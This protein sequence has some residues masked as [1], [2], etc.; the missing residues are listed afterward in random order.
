MLSVLFLQG[1]RF[2]NLFHRFPDIGYRGGT[3]PKANTRGIYHVI[4]FVIF[5]LYHS[6]MSNLPYRIRNLTWDCICFGAHI[7]LSNSVC[8]S[9]FWEMAID[10][11]LFTLLPF[12]ILCTCC[13]L[14]ILILDV[15]NIFSPLMC[16]DA[17]AVTFCDKHSSNDHFSC[18]YHAS[19]HFNRV[20]R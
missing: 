1:T 11:L 5:C 12:T 15:F 2:G 4:P 19:V 3:I 13:T 18:D 16:F 10:C 17:L 8:N 7:Y 6:S 14:I 9:R 20:F